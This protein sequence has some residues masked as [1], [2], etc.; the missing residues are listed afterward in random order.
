MNEILNKSKSYIFPLL[1]FLCVAIL[2]FLPQLQGKV[3]RQSDIVQYTAMAQEQTL[4]REKEGKE[5]LWT[6]SMFGGM[7]MY[8]IGVPLKNN[9]LSQIQNFMSLY[10]DRPIGYFF[11]GMVCFYIMMLSLG[12]NPWLSLLGSLIFAFSTNNLILFEAGHTSKL[13]VIFTSPLIIAGIAHLLKERYLLGAAIYGLGFGLNIY[14]SH[15]QMTYY[16]GMVLAVFFV[17]Y[18]AINRKDWL[19]VVK[20]LGIIGVMTLIGLGTSASQIWTTLEFT[21]DT[22][23]GTPILEKEAGSTEVTSSNTEGLDWEYAMQWSNGTKDLI[24]TFIPKAVGGGSGEWVEGNSTFAK[25]IGRRQRMQAPTYWGDLPF[26]SGPIYFGAV[27]MFL[28]IFGLFVIKGVY[29]WWIGL[30]V[31]LTY[32]LS[33]GKHFEILNRLI[34]DYLPLYNKFRAHSSVLS[35]TAILIPILGILTIDQLS[36]STDK[37]AYKKPLIYSGGI[38]GGLALILWLMGGSFFDFVSLSD[39]QYDQAI[40]NALIT[41]RKE[42][43]SSSALRTL[44]FVLLCGGLIWLYI[45]DKI[46]NTFLI[47]GIGLLAMFDLF[48]IDNDYF[49]HDSFVTARQLNSEFEPR[50]VDQQILQDPD[51]Y[52]RVYDATISTFNSAS[53]SYFHK[54]VGGYNAAKLQRFQDI[55]E[56]HI[57]QNNMK[58]INMLNTKYFIVNGPDNNPTA[59]LNPDALGNAWFVNQVKVVNTANEEINALTDFEPDSV[60]IMHKE[61]ESL[62]ANKTF[63]K[64]GEIKLTK[65][66]PE[67]LEFTTN[68]E[69]DQ[70]AVFSDIWYGPNKGWQAYIDGKEVEHARVNYLL[71]GLPIPKGQHTVVF[72]FKPNAYYAGIKINMISSIII[73]LLLIAALVKYYLDHKSKTT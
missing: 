13:K 43:L 34:F 25:A 38:L 39:T 46:K 45:H 18:I 17:T 4:Y 48:Q 31:L 70:F 71:R 21:K 12:I 2:Y 3:L 56:R 9:Y 30:A 7:P 41:Q 32:L 8:Q 51:P 11:L 52:Y 24:A 59:Q 6:N 60:A 73:I 69:N 35:V 66:H 62:V 1:I 29:K 10:F 36:K 50:P 40:Q 63:Q 54:T 42:M 5:I 37:L 57:T 53:T 20:T 68:S 27:V 15:P 65:Y 61:F 44:F 64:M 23:R 72:E 67:K 55:I 16:L 28:F 19:K 47:V 58:V 49:G 14:N 33:M 26:T 22:M